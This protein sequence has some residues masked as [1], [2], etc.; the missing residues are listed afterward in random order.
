M[1][2]GFGV[3]VGPRVGV[4]LGIAVGVLVGVGVCVGAGVFVTVAV[5][6]GLAVSVWAIA[7]SMAVWDGPHADITRV[8]MI[9]DAT[10]NMIFLFIFPPGKLS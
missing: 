5:D 10:V 6:V 9:I 3:L 4:G 2:F 7:S 8:M 1:R